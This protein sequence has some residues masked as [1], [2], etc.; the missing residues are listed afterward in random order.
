MGDDII[1]FALLIHSIASV[2]GL[3]ELP[4][5]LVFR[6]RVSLCSPGCPGTHSVDQAGLKLRNPPASAPQ[7]LGLK[8]CATTPGSNFLFLKHPSLLVFAELDGCVNIHY[9][10]AVIFSVLQDSKMAPF[11]VRV[12]LGMPV[13]RALVCFDFQ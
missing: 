2:T 9:Y 13:L 10:L 8:M 7:M 12:A 6:D 11:R 3:V 4:F 5:F 1:L